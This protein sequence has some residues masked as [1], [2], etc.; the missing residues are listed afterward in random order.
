MNSVICSARKAI[1]AFAVLVARILIHS[2]RMTLGV[3]LPTSCKF[4]PSCSHYAE[5]AIETYGAWRG[6][7]LALKRVLRCHPFARGGFDPVQRDGVK[8]IG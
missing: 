4:Y 3:V 2:Y 7:W 8:G 5:Q 1:S 6:G